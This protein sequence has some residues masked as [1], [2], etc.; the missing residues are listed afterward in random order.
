MKQDRRHS[1]RLEN[2]ATTTWRFRQL[3]G[4]RL[5]RGRCLA[6]VMPEPLSEVMLKECQPAAIAP[7]NFLPLSSAEERGQIVAT[8]VVLKPDVLPDEATTMRLQDPVKA[9][10]APYKSYKGLPDLDY[11]CLSG[12][13]LKH[14]RHTLNDPEHDL[15]KSLAEIG[16]SYSVIGA[17]RGAKSLLINRPT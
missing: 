17:G 5:R 10:I 12:K 15:T 6:L 11:P 13:A 1:P 3:N 8:F 16:V 7:A 2:N 4:D 14:L 9:N